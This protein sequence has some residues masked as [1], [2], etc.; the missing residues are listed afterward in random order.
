MGDDDTA[1][2]TGQGILQVIGLD[3]WERRGLTILIMLH[4]ESLSYLRA[5][6]PTVVVTWSCE[7][8]ITSARS[9]ASEIDT[10][11]FRGAQCN[12]FQVESRKDY[13]WH[14]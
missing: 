11:H 2:S 7:Y 3:I 6:S 8:N 13:C 12:G 4:A 10:F 5:L 9:L 14:H 1:S